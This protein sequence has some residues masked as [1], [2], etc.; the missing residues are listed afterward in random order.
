MQRRS[1]IVP[2]LSA[3][4]FFQYFV[5]G[6]WFATLGF[7]LSE[8]GLSSIIGTAYSI[9]GIAA[10]ISPIFLGM[11]TD[12]FFP[13]Q[14]V[15]GIVNIL[16]GILLWFL[17]TQI[18]SGNA[19][20]FLWLMFFYMLC[21]NPTYSL[22]NN[23]TFHNVKDSMRTFPLIRVCGTIGFIAAGLLIGSLGYSDNP[24]SLQIGAVISVFLGLYC[25]TLPN[26]PAPAKGKPF[27]A[28]DLLCLDALSLLKDR[29]YL[30]FIICTVLLFIDHAAYISFTSVFLGDLGINNVSSVLTI[31]QVSE[32]VFMLLIPLCFRFLG[33]KYMFLLGMLAWVVRMSLFVITGPESVA[34]LVFIA[35]ALHGLCWD[36]FFVTG[37]IYTDKVAGEKT[38]SQAQ[39]LLI[40]FTQGIGMFVGSFIAG[41]L[42]NQTVTEQGAAALSQWKI[43][44][45]YPAVIALVV[46]VFFF[47]FFKDKFKEIMQPTKNNEE[48]KESERLQA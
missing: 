26:T 24:L 45:M 30:I 5:L 10:I 17:P 20:G 43:F 4:M 7:V 47:I 44:W 33:F 46:T 6:S 2:R 11:I 41:N 48:V 3:M 29:Y 37:Y 32:I 35:I 16:G 18:Y 19:T 25:F 31:G 13:S 39:G 9:G 34:P 36:F 14:K 40:M 27:S 38:R 15:L 12:R 23:V 42:F 22:T 1:F 21:Y 8:H 28:R